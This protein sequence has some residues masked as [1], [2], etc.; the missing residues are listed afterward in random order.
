M[1]QTITGNIWTHKVVVDFTQLQTGSPD[2]VLN[3]SITTN[4]GGGNYHIST[5]T[6]INLTGM[7]A[8]VISGAGFGQTATV[9]SY[10]PNASVIYFHPDFSPTAL[11]TTSVIQF[12]RY[13]SYKDIFLFGLPANHIIVSTKLTTL[14]TFNAG[15]LDTNQ[16]SVYAFIGDGAMFPVPINAHD[17]LV[18]SIHGTYGVSNLTI[19]T[20]SD[21]TYEYG[22]FRWFTVSAPGDVTYAR[23][24]LP[25]N[26]TTGAYCV[27]SRIDARDLFCRFCILDVN[28]NTYLASDVPGLNLNW[29]FNSNVTSGVVE[30]AVQ[31]M[32]I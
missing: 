3:E 4:S 5:P 26:P 20:G 1:L 15:M 8:T 27:P 14:V 32:A 24:P 9:G 31:Y 2:I 30:L 21:A 28:D 6:P 12:T 22:T 7:T 19:P 23:N 16:N 29:N 18:T 13:N 11:D 17:T 25:G 10:T